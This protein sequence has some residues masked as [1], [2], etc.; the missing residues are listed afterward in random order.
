[1]ARHI[2]LLRGINV[3][4]HNLVAMARLREMMEGLGYH[5]VITH[6]QSGNVVFTAKAAAPAGEIRKIEAE[7]LASFGFPVRVVV[8]TRSELATVAG[9][10]PLAEIASDPSRMMVAFLSSAPDPARLKDIDSAVFKP[11]LFSIRGR[12]IYLWYPQ[13]AHATK[14]TNTLFEKRLQVT[15]TTRNWNTVTKLLALAGG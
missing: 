12:E 9:D 10:N 15:A 1:M 8:R 4:G 6:L 5:D 11:D 3:G 7:L 14:L 2:A 13:G